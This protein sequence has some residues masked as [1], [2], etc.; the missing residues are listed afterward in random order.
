MKPSIIAG[1]AWTSVVIALMLF[2]A[3]DTHLL[4]CMSLVG[5]SAACEAGQAAINQALWEYRTLPIIVALVSGYAGI[6]A[7][8]LIR[9]RDRSS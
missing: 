8:W 2:G 7:V 6:L 4:S 3:G 1:L 9:R 5:R